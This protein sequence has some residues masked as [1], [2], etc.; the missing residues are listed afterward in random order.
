MFKLRI[1][2][3]VFSGFLAIPLAA[4][5][6]M[7]A[8]GQPPPAGSVQSHHQPPYDSTKRN[9]AV[10]T[11][12]N[13][14]AR[15]IEYAATVLEEPAFD[16]FII[17]LGTCA[18]QTLPPAIEAKGKITII[19]CGDVPS[20]IY[21]DG[22]HARSMIR[23]ATTYG[24]TVV[25]SPLELR[26]V[27][28]SFEG[29]LFTASSDITIK[30][31]IFRRNEPVKA[32]NNVVI[33]TD[34]TTPS[35][36]KRGVIIEDCDME[37]VSVL[38]GD[39]AE[40]EIDIKRNRIITDPRNVNTVLELSSSSATPG[41]VEIEQNIFFGKQVKP[42]TAFLKI[43]RPKV[44][45]H[46][47]TFTSIASPDDAGSIVIE[48]APTA[49]HPPVADVT[50][51]NNL[52]EGGYALIN[53]KGTPLAPGAVTLR[54]NNLAAARS[55]LPVGLD[56][57]NFRHT[58]SPAHAFDAAQ[59]YW[60]AMDLNQV[61]AATNG[62][63]TV[64][65]KAGAPALGQQKPKPT[66]PPAPKPTPAPKPPAPS[67]PPAVVPGPQPAPGAPNTQ[68]APIPQPRPNDPGI[69]RTGLPVQRYAGETR[70][71]TATAISRV[72]P[73]A[74]DDDT[75]TVLLARADDAA[76]SV[77]AVPLA[78]SLDAPILLTSQPALHPNT[79]AEIKRRLP[80]GGRV[81]V[82]GGEAAISA[83]V[84][85]EVTA[86]GGQ[87][88]RI[89]GPNRAATAVATANVLKQDGKVKQILL[90]DGTD[91]QPDLIAGPVAAEVDGVTLLTNGK[92]MAPETDAF[93]KA[94]ASVPVTAIGTKAKEA[95]KVAKAIEAADGPALS[96]AV[97]K[98]FFTKPKAVGL[99]TTQSFADSLAGGAHIAEHDGPMILVD[100][101]ITD[102]A[103]RW[104]TTQPSVARVMIYG[105]Q[106]RIPDNVLEQ[107]TKP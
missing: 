7:P 54:H 88:T 49:G 53:P 26:G 27:A 32:G 90:V 80:K 50:V 76:D 30:N 46:E 104:I 3:A 65:P 82:M 95:G 5:S 69:A 57:D 24:G 93:L 2:S 68:P 22:S 16:E 15:T 36:K 106:G 38:R 37:W 56:Q 74:D 17:V 45:V 1:S 100:T 33:H 11:E 102:Q 23:P 78:D 4:F 12:A 62:V 66:P 39:T 92:A 20:G 52:F 86:L 18:H 63:V 14:L 67:Q 31:S 47:N 40:A 59:N 81:L 29:A 73:M 70:V 72:L 44:K 83:K 103:A 64:P 85:A 105:G 60:G 43:T 21:H 10:V 13:Q 25:R 99:A 98:H 41:R 35:N 19:G 96:L 9:I 107:F 77:S 91:W 6:F 94:H 48:G 89:A 101:A 8:H 42:G 28:I 55:V 61:Q 79:A 34:Y 58:V 84:V 75:P 71:E 87:V 97:A 51:T